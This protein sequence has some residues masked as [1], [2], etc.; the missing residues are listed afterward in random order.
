MG[1]H[2]YDMMKG[3]LAKTRRLVNE[4][5]QA[6][7]PEAVP[8]ES[9]G[10]AQSLTPEEL[11][12]EIQRFQNSVSF[13]VQFNDFVLNGTE[14]HWSGYLTDQQLQFDFTLDNADGCYISCE[15]VQ[16]NQAAVETI[17]KLF[18]YYKEWSTRWR[19]E[20]NKTQTNAA[21]PPA[22]APAPAAP[23]PPAV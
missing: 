23:Q 19:E 10:G 20:L 9:G 21:Q 15:M 12:S 18:G 16:L 3:M 17:Q 5:M 22:P 8:Q 2:D 4:G 7:A 14:S 13:Q 1:H 6:M 11:R